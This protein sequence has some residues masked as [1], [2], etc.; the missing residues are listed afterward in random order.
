MSIDHLHFTQQ[1][2]YKGPPSL[3][4]VGPTR[5]LVWDSRL[6]KRPL[7]VVLNS[8]FLSTILK[9]TNT[10][11]KSFS[12]NTALHTYFSASV[13]GALVEA[14]LGYRTLNKDPDP[15][16]SFSL[17]YLFILFPFQGICSLRDTEQDDNKWP[18]VMTSWKILQEC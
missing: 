17:A 1:W 6:P 7:K 14:R 13:T 11:R 18:L 9:M 3:R 16:A 15:M 4:S 12:F 10:D 8:K 5:M 2:P